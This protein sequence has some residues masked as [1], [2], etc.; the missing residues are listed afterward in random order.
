[1]SQVT[2]KID[3]ILATHEVPALE[4]DVLKQI[5]EIEKKYI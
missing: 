2:E 5:E 1:M 4:P 3:N